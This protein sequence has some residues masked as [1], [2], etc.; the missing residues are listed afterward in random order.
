MLRL[1]IVLVETKSN[2][3]HAGEWRGMVLALKPFVC[4]QC[5]PASVLCPAADACMCDAD[6]C[7]HCT[8]CNGMALR[9]RLQTATI[10]MLFR[11]HISSPVNYTPLYL[12]MEPV[13]QGMTRGT[14]FSFG[15]KSDFYNWLNSSV[16]QVSAGF[17]IMPE[18]SMH[19][20]VCTRL[21]Q[22]CTCVLNVFA[23]SLMTSAL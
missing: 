4:S 14:S 21:T 10:L 11:L 8:A 13:P 9:Y 16:L 20:T 23:T 18:S 17:G 7:N 12:G 6:V 22:G 5:R 2:W 15:D 1:K 19:C 3:V